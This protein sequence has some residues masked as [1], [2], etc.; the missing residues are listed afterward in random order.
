MPV[1]A[2]PPFLRRLRDRLQREERGRWQWFSSDSWAEDY[3]ESVRLELLQST[4][5]ME[6]ASHTGLY[7]AAG[8]ALTALEL[9]IPVTFYQAQAEDGAGMNAGLCFLPGEGHIVLRGPVL[10]TLR[11]PEL[12]ALIGHELAHYLLWTV[13]DGSLR[14]ASEVMESVAGHSGA[15]P[16]HVTTALRARRYA[17]IYADRGSHLVCGDPRPVVACLVKVHTGLAEV[18]PEAYVR[19][20]D[21]IFAKKALTSEGISHPETFIR[22]RAIWLWHER[23]NEAEE[24]VAAMVQGP[25]SL[26]TLDLLD[27]HDLTQHTRSLLSRVLEPAWFRSDPVLAHARAFF[28]DE[29]PT[30]FEPAPLEKSQLHASVID[31]FSYVLLDFAVVD[32]TLGEVALAHAWTLA[33]TVGFADTF[34]KVAREELKMTKRAFEEFRKQIPSLLTRATTQA[35]A[36]VP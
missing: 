10:A 16:S 35:A 31:Y 25:T 32:E 9:D 15:K 33:D 12:A 17:E 20:A 13:E 27:Q 8:R 34:Q 2:L 30:A 6:E 24:T 14:V 29:D 3:A 21:E 22:A 18:N 28:P 7:A 26:D 5:R 4:Y 19:Q 23:T 11:E 1:L 36:E